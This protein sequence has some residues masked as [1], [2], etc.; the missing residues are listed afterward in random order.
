MSAIGPD[1]HHLAVGQRGDA[2]A[3]RV[4]AVEVV[5]DHEH[6]EPERLLQRPDQRVEVAG[7]D[8]IEARGRLVEEHDLRDRA[9]ARGRAPR[10]WS[11][12]RT[13][14]RETCRRRRRVEPDHLELGHRHLVASAPRDRSRYSR[15]GNCTFCSTVSEE[16]SAPC[17]NRTPQRRSIARR[18]ARR[19]PCRDRRPA[20]RSCP[21]AW[22]ARPMIVRSSTDLPLPEPPTRP[23]ISPRRTSSDRWS[24]TTCSPKPTTRSRTRIAGIGASVCIRAHIPIEAKKMANRPSSTITRKIDFTTEVVVCSPSDSALPL[25]RRPSRRRRRRSPAP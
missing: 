5:G 21:A 16:N 25:T 23:R 15:I 18:S 7:G 8:R 22:A 4:Q 6:G 20:P 19:S 2:V 1:R 3:D 11:C 24:S 12:R 17:W 10:A 13:A 14:R 9:R